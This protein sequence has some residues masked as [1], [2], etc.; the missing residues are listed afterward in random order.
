[1]AAL[2]TSRPNSAEWK[3]ISLDDVQQAL[4]PARDLI[5]SNFSNSP[6]FPSSATKFHSA[7][8]GADHGTANAAATSARAAQAES[9]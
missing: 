2:G 8:S 6:Y 4:A 9:F 1:V 3:G 7:G 5:L